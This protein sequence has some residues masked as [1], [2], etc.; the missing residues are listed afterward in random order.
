MMAHTHMLQSVSVQ[1]VNG[2]TPISHSVFIHSE[3]KQV[4]PCIEYLLEQ[5][6]RSVGLVHY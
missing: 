5:L 6:P 4:R 3:A 1:P 2:G